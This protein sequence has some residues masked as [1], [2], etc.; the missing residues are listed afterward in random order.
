VSVAPLVIDIGTKV[1]S[2]KVVFETHT[3]EFCDDMAQTLVLLE[4]RGSEGR[5]LS[6]KGAPLGGHHREGIL[7]LASRSSLPSALEL[8]IRRPGETS[9]RSFRRSLN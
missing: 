5:P 8:R 7:T 3:Q 4:G 2:F 9:A 6:W 1:W